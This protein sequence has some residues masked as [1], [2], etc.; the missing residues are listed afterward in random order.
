MVT[1]ASS[2]S[3][4]T[5]RDWPDWPQAAAPVEKYA[6]FGGRGDLVCSECVTDCAVREK[7]LTI[8]SDEVCAYCDGTLGPFGRDTDV[9][10]YVYRCLG[11]EYGDPWHGPLFY[12]TEEDRHFGVTKLNTWELL[13]EV[14]SPFADGSAVEQEFE[15]LIEHE[16]YRLDSQV[17]EYHEQLVWGW[18]SFERRLINGPRFLFSLSEAE[19]G[20]K[21]ARSLFGFLATFAA[22]VE[23][24][25]VK[26]CKPGRVLYRAR[27]AQKILRSARKLG[28]PSP[29]HTGPQRMSAA[30][31]SC[32]YAAEYK[33]TA[34]KEVPAKRTEQVSVGEWV[35]TRPLMYA[36]F[37]DEPTLPSL[38]DFPRSEQRPYV[39]FLREFVERIRRSPDSKIGDANSYLATQVLAEYLRFGMPVAGGHGLDAVRYPSAKGDGGI[40]WVIFGRPDRHDPPSVKLVAA[41]SGSG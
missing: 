8:H 37:A 19:M 25:F 26:T 21:S 1:V 10:E 2:D 35:T 39:F 18:D 17:G 15:T 36:D 32:F 16:W 12:D 14:D 6:T 31:V 4:E 5:D 3:E 34:V 27:A 24:N 22:E 40:N 7:V 20:E 13:N 9:F 11:Q 30:G 38:F 41:E 29:K 23:S 28:S 33:A